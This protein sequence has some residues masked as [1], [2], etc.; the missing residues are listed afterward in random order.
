MQS[1]QR[2]D[3]IPQKHHFIQPESGPCYES[4]LF[5]LELTSAITCVIKHARLAKE[6]NYGHDIS[7][8]T[9]ALYY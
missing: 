9:S 5:G 7:E 3:Y 4:Y 1:L 8:Q 2:Y 6:K